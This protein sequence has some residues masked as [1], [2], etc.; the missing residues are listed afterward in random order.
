[1]I[2]NCE[3][4][5]IEI[6]RR[7]SQVKRAAHVTC[8]KACA[9]KMFIKLSQETRECLHCRTEF[10][11]KASD[12]KKYCSRS[13]ASTAINLARPSSVK[14]CCRCCGDLLKH[15]HSTYCNPACQHRHQYTIWAAQ[16]KLDWK[17]PA[18]SNTRVKKYIS[19]KDGYLCS[20][21]GISEWGGKPITL[22]LDH[23]DGNSENNHENNLRLLCP[24]CHSQTDTYG[25][26]NRGNGRKVRRDK[27][28][29]TAEVD[30]LSQI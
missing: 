20:C 6:D 4:C 5:N 15:L 2:V 30:G 26:K 14:P 13:C 17:V 28:R 16:Y 9:G 12:A 29:E 19:L 25:G 10:T 3:N 7:P 23:V 18:T 21:C 27:R 24:N 8:S 11:A 22:E 1:M